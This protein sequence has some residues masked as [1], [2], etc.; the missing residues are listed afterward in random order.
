MAGAESLQSKPALA[1]LFWSLAALVR[2]GRARA[3][4]SSVAA[5][6][7]WPFSSRF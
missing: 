2:A 4:L 6:V 5:A 7:C 1:A 3:T